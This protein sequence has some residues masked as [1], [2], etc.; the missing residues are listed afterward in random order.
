[1]KTLLKTDKLI[2]KIEEL[3]KEYTNDS[4]GAVALIALLNQI[5]ECLEGLKN[6]LLDHRS[7][8][9][10][11]QIK[12]ECLTCKKSAEVLGLEVPSNRCANAT[13]DRRFIYPIECKYP[14]TKSY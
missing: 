4:P 7:D 1:M 13:L 12:N 10:T 3:K 11:E 6:S 5:E 8:L 9:H 2:L 14:E